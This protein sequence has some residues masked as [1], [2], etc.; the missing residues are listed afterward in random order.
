MT[1]LV[2]AVN[3]PNSQGHPGGNYRGRRTT[4]A[5]CLLLLA[6]VGLLGVFS[7]WVIHPGYT[8]QDFRSN[9]WKD[10]SA[11]ERGWMVDD[12]LQQRRLV[13]MSKQEVV[14]LLGSPNHEG[15]V[16]FFYSV[17]YMGTRRELPFA[18]PYRLILTFD[19]EQVVSAH[20]DD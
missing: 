17:G 20:V 9:L 4:R 2:T 12:L 15:E 5:A 7:V 19:G 16:N 13:G 11:E 10:A 8:R 1:L 3:L 18:F 14:S 6:A